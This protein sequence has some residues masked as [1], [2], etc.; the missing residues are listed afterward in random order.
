MPLNETICALTFLRLF[1]FSDYI[2][3]IEIFRLS[4]CLSWRCCNKLDIIWVPTL[5]FSFSYLECMSNNV[6][7]N[8]AP[9]TTAISFYHTCKTMTSLQLVH[10]AASLSVCVITESVG[11]FLW[12]G[13]FL[14]T[15]VGKWGRGCASWPV[16]MSVISQHFHGKW[17][18]NVF[19]V[20]RSSA[21][22][23]HHE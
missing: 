4:L 10:A 18:K 11:I 3:A 12:G 20:S 14:S 13:G 6:Y 19:Q 21:L 8:L 2:V 17:K 5:G 16:Y 9:E 7:G 22:H 1:E 15:S 23:N